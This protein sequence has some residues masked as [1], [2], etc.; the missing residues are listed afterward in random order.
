MSLAVVLLLLAFVILALAAAGLPS[1]G[2]N[3]LAL[4]LAVWVLSQ[5]AAVWRH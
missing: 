1:R 2:L 3:L 5:L 4:G